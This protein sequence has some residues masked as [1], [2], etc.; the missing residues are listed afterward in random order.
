[1]FLGVKDREYWQHQHV[2]PLIYYTRVAMWLVLQQIPPD[3][4]KYFPTISQ[5]RLSRCFLPQQWQIQVPHL[6]F[7]RLGSPFSIHTKIKSLLTG[8]RIGEYLIKKWN[9]M[10]NFVGIWW[11][12]GLQGSSLL[13]LG[14]IWCP[15][16]C[17]KR[18]FKQWKSWLTFCY[19]NLLVLCKNYHAAIFISSFIIDFT[20]YF[21][22]FLHLGFK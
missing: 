3:A 12:S 13:V 7:G 8:F 16:T 9:E 2:L 11:V 10:K 20:G 14:W 19:G 5:Q 22:A 6:I 17:L 1:M 4:S 15:K 21:Y 18:N